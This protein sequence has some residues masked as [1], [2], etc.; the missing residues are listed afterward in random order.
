MNVDMVKARIDK[1]SDGSVMALEVGTTGN[2]VDDILY[3]HH[4]GRLLELS[5]RW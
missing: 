3:V 1:F 4:L 2:D 5:R